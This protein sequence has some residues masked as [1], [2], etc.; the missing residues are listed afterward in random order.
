MKRRN[1]IKKLAKT[2]G[3]TVAGVCSLSAEGKGK[4][5][6]EELAKIPTRTIIRRMQE[7]V[8]IINPG[9]DCPCRYS[10]LSGDCCIS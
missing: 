5:V 9:R 4:D 3:I 6:R 1:F 10:C 2:M 8:C 7:G